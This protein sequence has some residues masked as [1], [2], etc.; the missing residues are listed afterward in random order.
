MNLRNAHLEEAA[1]VTTIASV[2][3]VARL[4]RDRKMRHIYVVD[5]KEFPVGVV[6]ITDVN[7]K[8][9]AEGKAPEGLLARDIMTAPLHTVDI[10]AEIGRAYAEMIAHDTYSIPVLEHGLL[11]GVFSMGEALKLL[12]QQK[13]GGA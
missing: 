7:A 6:S 1:T 13:R 9:V 12:V 10:D 3:E 8:I 4:L 2:I 5:E 11:V